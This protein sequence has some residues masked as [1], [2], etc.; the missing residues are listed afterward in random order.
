[1]VG[2][3]DTKVVIVS[4]VAAGFGTVVAY[5]TG[6]LATNVFAGSLIGALWAAYFVIGLLT[7]GSRDFP[8]DVDTFK[9]FFLTLLGI[10]A[11]AGLITLAYSPAGSVFGW[12][13]PEVITINA[14]FSVVLGLWIAAKLGLTK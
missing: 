1:M 2:M 14:T 13:K 11:F 10:A 9:E 4:L 12:F 7:F 6:W 3:I 8:K 5:A